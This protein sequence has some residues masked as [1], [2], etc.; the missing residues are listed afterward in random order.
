MS[1][2]SLKVAVVRRG[3]EAGPRYAMND[4]MA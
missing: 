1:P 3:A 2:F 4:P